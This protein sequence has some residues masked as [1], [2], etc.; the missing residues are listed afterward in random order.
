MIVV[1]LLAGRI[2]FSAARDRAW[3][4]RANTV[5][6]RLDPQTGAPRAAT[7][8]MGAVALG[9]CTVPERVLLTIISG[10]IVIIY[11]LL[12]SAVIAGRRSGATAH[13]SYRMPL[14]PWPPVLA[15]CALAGIVWT[16]LGDAEVGGPGLLATAAIVLLAVGYY[17]VALHGRGRYASRGP[18]SA[19]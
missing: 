19:R 7:L 4:A 18:G 8:T 1:A 11:G 15:L 14:F 12:C 9:W 6:A 16:S 3:P 5:L 2:L 17:R 13:G 10:G